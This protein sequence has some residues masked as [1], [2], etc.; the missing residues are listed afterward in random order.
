MHYS[1]NCDSINDK[2]HINNEH[3]YVFDSLVLYTLSLL[4]EVCHSKQKQTTGKTSLMTE[5][6]TCLKDKG[7]LFVKLK[8]HVY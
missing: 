6:F 8:L 3:L 4:L 5:H 2:L 7:I 1:F